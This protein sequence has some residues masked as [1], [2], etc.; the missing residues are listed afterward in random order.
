MLLPQLECGAHVAH[1]SV[2]PDFGRLR[3]AAAWRTQLRVKLRVAGVH[4]KLDQIDVG[5]DESFEFLATRERWSKHAAVR[6]HPN[7]RALLLRILDHVDHVRMQ[8][9]LAAAR[10]THPR[11]VL[12]TLARD[13]FPEFHRK[14]IAVALTVE[15]SYFRVAVGVRT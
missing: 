10:A 6:V 3:H 5:F 11:V 4:R 2:P 15:L 9:R 12:P 1:L 14:E 8:H 13:A 7:T